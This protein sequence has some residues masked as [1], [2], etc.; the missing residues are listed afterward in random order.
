ME[1]GQSRFVSIGNRPGILEGICV[2]GTLKET[3]FND[4]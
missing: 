2:I 1:G 4:G 3:N